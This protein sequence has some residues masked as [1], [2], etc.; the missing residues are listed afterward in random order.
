MADKVLLI[1]SSEGQYNLGIEKIHNWF[2]RQG[3]YVLRAMS[4]PELWADEFDK[5]FISAIFSWDVPHLVRQ[6]Q[7]ALELGKTVEVGGPGTFG[8][9]DY[10]KSATG[11]TAQ[12]TPDA[13]FEREPGQYEMVFWSRGCPAKNCSL[14]FPRDGALPICSVPAMEGWR[15]TLY[16]D[17]TPAP[18][19]LDNN[20]SALPTEHQELIIERT[21]A[22]GFPEVDAKEGFEPRSFKL[23]T[24]MRWKRLPLKLW[25]FAYDELRERS[26]VMRMMSILDEAGVP[27]RARRIY[28]IAGNESIEICEQRVREIHEWGAL[29]VVQRRRPLDWLGG[30]LPC[31]FDWTEQLLIDFQRWGNRLAGGMTFAEYKRSFKDSH[32]PHVDQ[33]SFL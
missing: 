12:S 17:V 20:L 4:V 13:R 30:P 27:R 5:V 18:A 21:L 16:K 14:G 10:I 25:R 29:P 3:A 23:G 28:C 19:I 6:A 15:F 32:L 1:N 8:T 7:A 9:Q 22:A 31:L 26:D 33:E 11:L 2:N 24:A